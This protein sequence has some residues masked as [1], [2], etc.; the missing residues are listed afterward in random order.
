MDLSILS[1]QL[2]Q[3]FAWQTIEIKALGEVNSYFNQTFKV[4]ADGQVYALQC[5]PTQ[6]SVFAKNAHQQLP[7]VLAALNIPQRKQ[8]YPHR[9]LEMI[10]IPNGD[11]YLPSQVNGQQVELRL[12]KWIDSDA[13]VQVTES[14]AFETGKILADFHLAVQHVKGLDDL[15]EHAIEPLPHFHDS[16]WYLQHWQQAITNNQWADKSLNLTEHLATIEQGVEL[17]K[18]F[19]SFRQQQLAQQPRVMH[20]DPKLANILFKQQHAVALID[21]DTIMTGLWHY[22]VADA[23]RSLCNS[24]PENGDINQ[25]SFDLKLFAAF[26]RGYA[27]ALLVWTDQE[28]QM[29]S[30]AIA[31]LPLELGIRFLFGCHK[32]H[33]LRLEPQPQAAAHKALIQLRL[34]KD[35]G[36]KQQQIEDVLQQVMPK[37]LITHPQHTQQPPVTI[38]TVIRENVQQLE[39]FYSLHSEYDLLEVLAPAPLVENTENKAKGLWQH[40]CLEFFAANKNQSAYLEFNGTS[41]QQSDLFVF[42]AERVNAQGLKT[43]EE[44]LPTCATQA[45]WQW[46]YTQTSNNR[47]MAKFSLDLASVANIVDSQKNIEYSVTA[48]VED[49]QHRHYYLALQHCRL[50]PDFHARESFKII[51]NT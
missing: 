21:F 10:A 6:S 14:I 2:Q 13:V 36:N 20:G 7:Q 46:F 51:K 42:S 33:P 40:N 25:V 30:S 27:P 44:I 26:M 12:F 39:V 17:I 29:L 32:N 38:Q 48:V 3:Y 45:Q 9:Y 16:A 1:Q 43:T 15:V 49:A 19:D 34:F 23:L 24:Q 11:Y 37:T 18:R 50:Q 31:L 28:K 35:I 8:W 22:D 4:L 47:A 5:V 41:N